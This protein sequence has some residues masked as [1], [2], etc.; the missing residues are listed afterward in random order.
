MGGS[1]ILLI[2][3]VILIL[4]GADKLPE[5]ARGLGKG[6]NEVRKASEEIKQELLRQSSEISN[7]VEEVK[8][9]LNASSTIDEMRKEIEN[10]QVENKPNNEKMK[11]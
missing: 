10:L 6:L 11:P 4:F 8:K 7:E 1:E 5:L 2:L 9:G 3:L